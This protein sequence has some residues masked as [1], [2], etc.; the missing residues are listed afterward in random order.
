[1]NPSR[2]AII[3]KGP[4]TEP[5]IFD[6]LKKLFFSGTDETEYILLEIIQFP[7]CGN[8][9]N[10]YDLLPQDELSEEGESS[11]SIDTI[12]LLQERVRNFCQNGKR[13]K[14]LPGLTEE[15]VG[16][17]LSY[18]RTDFSQL[19]LFFDIELQDRRDDKDKI[20]RQLT[21][22]F[23]NETENG[24]LYVNYPM[25]ESL[26]DIGTDGACYQDCLVPV[27]D[28][29][30]YKRLVG[31]RTCLKNVSKYDEQT[32]KLLC[33]RAVQRS[34]CLLI[35]GCPQGEALKSV[36]FLSFKEHREQ[37]SQNALYVRQ[38]ENH[39]SAKSEVMVLSSIPLFLLD[40]YQ[41]SFWKKMVEE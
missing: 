37:G 17:L 4:R 6:S 21:N 15:D 23:S 19:F 11:L 1:M 38:Y 26:K 3:L 33:K 30:N 32:W 39:I 12:P 41:E 22:V 14:L 29:P 13:T 34:S 40:Y 27:S 24:K 36:P 7:F 18:K 10:F 8:I 28:I 31:A 25:V 16:R 35:E 5:P 20:I 2:I 9:Y